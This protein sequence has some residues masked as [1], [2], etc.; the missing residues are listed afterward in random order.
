MQ[1]LLIEV[2]DVK[3]A[4]LSAFFDP[5]NARHHQAAK[6]YRRRFLEGVVNLPGRVKCMLVLESGSIVRTQ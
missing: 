3:T 4:W 6:S 1:Q 5:S 2:H